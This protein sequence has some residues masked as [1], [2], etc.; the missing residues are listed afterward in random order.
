MRETVDRAAV[1]ERAR[2]P[3]PERRY[4]YNGENRPPDRTPALRPNKRPARRKVSTFNLI[5]LLFTAGIAIVLY[6]N[7]IIAVNHLAFEISQL[8]AKYD[9]LANANASLR[10]ELSRKMALERI[11]AVAAD[12]LNLQHPA[13]QPVYFEIDGSLEEDLKEGTDR[14]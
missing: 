1:R 12:Q 4:I 11:S 13:E 3:Q 2:L 10:A 8:Q 14:Q 5:V 6:V 7:N 9:G